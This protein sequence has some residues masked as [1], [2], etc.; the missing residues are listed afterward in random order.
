MDVRKYDRE[1]EIKDQWAIFVRAQHN[2]WKLYQTDGYV[3]QHYD[4]FFQTL[5]A[6][7]GAMAK[8]HLDIHDRNMVLAEMIAKATTSADHHRLIMDL[9]E[10]QAQAALLRGLPLFPASEWRFEVNDGWLFPQRLA[11]ESDDKP[12]DE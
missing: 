3:K 11:Q 4:A 12:V 6:V 9:A 7:E 1:Q 2:G 5:L 10:R 8:C